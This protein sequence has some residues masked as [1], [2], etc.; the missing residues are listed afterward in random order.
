MLAYAVA[1]LMAS[2]LA[3]EPAGEPPQAW[4]SPTLG[5][6]TWVPAGV[7]TMGS[8]EGVGGADEHPAHQ[9][10][11]S[12]GFWIMEHEVTQREWK[13]VMGANPSD[14]LACGD[15]CPV[16]QVSWP[17]AMLF[18]ARAA[19]RDGV[20]Y[21][22]PTEAEW[23]YA[24][25]QVLSTARAEAAAWRTG[26]WCGAA[27]L[28]TGPCPVC[29]SSRSGS[30]LCDMSGNVWEWTLDAYTPYAGGS[31]IDPV[32]QGGLMMVARGGSWATDATWVRPSARGRFPLTYDGGDMGLRLIR[33]TE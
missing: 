17:D 18:A 2:A 19:A 20:N 28:Q 5:R 25:K 23:E 14:F 13:V 27:L 30:P 31:A 11:I 33:T 29:T 16:E 12:K 7:F 10:S 32:G 21:R 9:V 3:V 26:A 4:T 8:P 1:W 6:M 24:A 15:R 22:P